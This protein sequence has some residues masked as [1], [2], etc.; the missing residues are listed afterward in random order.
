VVT[1][2]SSPAFAQSTTETLPTYALEPNGGAC[3]A[4]RL[5]AKNKVFGTKDAADKF[6][7]HKGCRCTVIDGQQLSPEVYG[8]VFPEKDGAA[9]RRDPRTA[10]LLDKGTIDGTPVPV[11][12]YTAP[13]LLLA[14]G[15]GIW[16]WMKH[17]DKEV[18]PAVI[19][20]GD[21]K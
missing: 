13:V 10:E 19:D 15:G 3:N 18:E 20:K 6:R 12:A 17:R 16:W 5:H 7:A 4:C 1:L 9:D 2:G 8:A 11:V 14:A 21:W